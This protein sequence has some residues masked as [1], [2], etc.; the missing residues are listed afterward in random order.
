MKNDQGKVNFTVAPTNL[1]V[2]R[3]RFTSISLTKNKEEGGS[4]AFPCQIC[5]WWD[6]QTVPKIEKVSKSM[7]HM[8][9][10]IF[11]IKNIYIH[12]QIYAIFIK[13]FSSKNEIIIPICFVLCSMTFYTLCI[14][15]QSRIRLLLR[16][17]NE[18]SC[19]FLLEEE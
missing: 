3:S 5:L 8:V 15:R 4:N 12:L 1:S 2:S 18:V 13:N 7:L 14:L 11:G 16:K 6:L 19:F 9:V 17:M 10:P